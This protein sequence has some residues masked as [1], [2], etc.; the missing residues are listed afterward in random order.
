MYKRAGRD[1]TECAREMCSG[2]LQ[3]D[4]HQDYMDLQQHMSLKTKS[5]DNGVILEFCAPVLK[6]RPQQEPQL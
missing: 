2:Q 5:H 4:M 3:P 6:K 1:N